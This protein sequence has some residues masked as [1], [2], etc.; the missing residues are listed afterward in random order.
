[1]SIVASGGIPYSDVVNMPAHI[2]RATIEAISN[3]VKAELELE[4]EK[5][6]AMRKIWTGK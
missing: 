4:V 2:R 1:M 3:R 6:K 5:L